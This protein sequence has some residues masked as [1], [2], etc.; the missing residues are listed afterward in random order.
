MGDIDP[1]N[2]TSLSS[3]PSTDT[4]SRASRPARA[5]PFR[6]T[7]YFSLTSLIGLLVVTASLFWTYRE[8]TERQ[9]IEHESRAN[10]D[11]T[12]AFANAVWATHRD[13]VLGSSGRTRDAL[14]AD[15]AQ[16]RLL[17]DVHAQMKGLPIAKVKVYNLDGVTVFSTDARQIG[18]SRQSNAGFQGAAA[19]QVMSNITFR[20]KFDAFEKQIANRSLI[21]S[22]IPVRT[23][24]DGAIEGVF[25]VYSDVTDL[26]SRQ[27]RAQWRIAAVVVAL[28]AT[29]YLFL[30]L[31]VR[32]A[33]AILSAQERDRASKEAEIR[34]RAYHDALTGLPNRAYFAER[35]DEVIGAAGRHGHICALMFIDLDRFK[36]VNDSLGHH[37]GDLLL[38]QVARLFERHL[39]D[40]DLL[41]RMGGDEFTI[42]LP[43]ISAPEDA[44]YMARRIASALEEPILI[45]EHELSVGATIGIA[46]FPGDGERA[47]ALIKNADAAM[48]A[49]KASGRG[50]HAFYRT[51]MNLRASQRLS[52]ETAL[53]KGFRDGEFALYYQPRLDAGSRRVVAV[54]ALLRW[55]SPTRGVV[56]P[57]SFIGVLEDIGMMPI[58]GEWV[59]RNACLQVRRWHEQGFATLRVSVNVSPVQFQSDTFVA[60]VARVLQETGAPAGSI[61][62]EL[63]E[64]LLIEDAPKTSETISALKSLGLRIS[65]DDFGTGYSSL[66]YLR[67]FPVDYLKIDRSFV[68]DIPANPRD[69]AVATA[70][71][72]LAKSLDMTVVAEGVENEAQAAFFTNASC[73]ELQGFL[74]SRPLPVDQLNGV[75]SSLVDSVTSE[76]LPAVTAHE[77]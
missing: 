16:T 8:L 24:P 71:I 48:Y 51:E 17:A 44:A 62:L 76:R 20:E 68:S 59:L 34:H 9:L 15:P 11:L 52:L 13:F 10:A 28:L 29:L 41:F 60:S 37:A 18:E 22:Y 53:Q 31:V 66:N 67:K 30:S 54:E 32:K 61:E 23:K 73:H 64:S 65:I 14:V 21:A 43:N 7:R 50:G 39:H 57:A 46:I 70:I 58:V 19:G 2:A 36:I 56:L 75:L 33:D 74:F 77:A 40:G 63:T 25:E 47:E 72:D 69:S 4:D 55:V 45:H 49:A 27:S 12:Q 6:L 42:I 5:T 38:Q 35:L 3:S 1:M 26:V